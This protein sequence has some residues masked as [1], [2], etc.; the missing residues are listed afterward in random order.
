VVEKDEAVQQV[1]SELNDE[2][3]QL[4]QTAASLR[5]E[6]ELETIQHHEKYQELERNT[7]DETRQLHE[8]IASLRDRLEELENH[9]SQ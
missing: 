1:Q 9:E 7:R 3:R 6:L 4:R 2:I 8:T 5:D